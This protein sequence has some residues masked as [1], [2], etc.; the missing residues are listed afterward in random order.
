MCRFPRGG[1]ASKMCGPT[2]PTGSI[3]QPSG[4]VA[5]WIAEEQ[6]RSTSGTPALV[7]ST[8]FNLALMKAAI[9]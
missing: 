3:P 8:A 2:T 6:L 5:R 1:A 4:L 9:M 7:N